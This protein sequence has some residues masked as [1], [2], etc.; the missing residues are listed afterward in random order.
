[1]LQ[2]SNTTCKILLNNKM[3][4]NNNTTRK[5]LQN[6]NTIRIIYFTK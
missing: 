6:N 1:M 5:M 3:L 4:Q 2:N